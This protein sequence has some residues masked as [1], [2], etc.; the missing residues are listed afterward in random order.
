MTVI[1]GSTGGPF[2]CTKHGVVTGARTTRT[3]DHVFDLEGRMAPN[4]RC[5]KAADTTLLNILH[6]PFALFLLA[7]D[8]LQ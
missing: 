2:D 3:A 5:S 4:R 8:N 7:S 6:R 1:D